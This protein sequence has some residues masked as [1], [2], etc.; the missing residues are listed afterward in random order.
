MPPPMSIVAMALNNPVPCMSGAAGR[1]SGPGLVIVPANP[2]RS[3]PG[4]VGL[5]AVC[6]ST[7]NR[8]SWRH[9]TPLGMPVVPPV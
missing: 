2:S 5:P 4:G 9:M 8:S 3:C 7:R 6:S 1:L